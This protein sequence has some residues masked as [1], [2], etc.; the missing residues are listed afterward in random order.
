MEITDGKKS[1]PVVGGV[2]LRFMAEQPEGLTLF[3]VERAIFIPE[4]RR[5]L[6]SDQKV[7]L[8]TG[9]M[10]IKIIWV[11]HLRVG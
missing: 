3:A 4:L 5:D 8:M 6:I 11:A 10:I 9:S 2:L 1:V 7:A